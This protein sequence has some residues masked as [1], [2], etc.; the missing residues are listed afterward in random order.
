MSAAR[1][2]QPAADPVATAAEIAGLRSD[3]DNLSSRVDQLSAD[4]RTFMAR[5][6]P[7]LLNRSGDQER[8]ARV[9]RLTS[10]AH[11]RLDTFS[12]TVAALRDRQN[13]VFWMAGAIVLVAQ[14][15]GALLF[16]QSGQALLRQWLSLG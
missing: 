9:E 5:L 11:E 1:A 3:V 14:A 7:M 10:S 15:F 2:N 6:E 8:L 4:L 12:I 13:R 16:S